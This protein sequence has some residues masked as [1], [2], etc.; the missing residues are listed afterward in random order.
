MENVI[1]EVCGQTQ[2]IDNLLVTF[3]KQGDAKFHQV[4]TILAEKVQQVV[5]DYQFAKEVQEFNEEFPNA[6]VVKII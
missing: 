1:L 5:D 4:A 2:G 3:A 6:K